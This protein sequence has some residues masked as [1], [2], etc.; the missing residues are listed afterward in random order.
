MKKAKFLT[1]VAGIALFL[2]MGVSARADTASFTIDVP[3][4]GLSGTPGPYATVTL[5]L[6]GSAID[7]TVTMDSTFN[8]FGNGQGGGAFGFNVVGSEAGLAVTGLTPN[9][10]YTGAGLVADLGGGQM[11][12]FGSFDVTIQDGTSN[13]G[14][15][16]MSFTVTRDGGFSS[17]DQLVE[18]SCGGDFCGAH[19]VVHVAPG[20][21]IPTGFAGDGGTPVPEPATLTLLGTGLLG[22][23]GAIRRRMSR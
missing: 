10:G 20:P 18:E 19:F 21:N 8:M 22:L 11:D 15:T 12:G 9:G 23:A 13:D 17:V 6:N 1:V 16:S 7:V 4:S 3:N 5:T 14:L 2:A